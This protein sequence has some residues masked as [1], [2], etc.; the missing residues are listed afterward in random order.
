MDTN[1]VNVLSGD[2]DILASLETPL[3]VALLFLS[4]DPL[5]EGS[6]VQMC[7]L[8]FWP[9]EQNS[10]SILNNILNYFSAIW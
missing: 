5:T 1:S 3:P 10:A 2:V 9:P 8:D 6:G 4:G 7:P